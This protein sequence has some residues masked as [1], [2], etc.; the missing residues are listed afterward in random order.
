MHSWVYDLCCALP[1][2]FLIQMCCTV[3][4]IVPIESAHVCEVLLLQAAQ[5]RNYFMLKVVDG[6]L[7]IQSTIQDPILYRN[8]FFAQPAAVEVKYGQVREL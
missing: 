8:G 1:Q 3:A 5:W 6:Y 2:P 7:L 4:I